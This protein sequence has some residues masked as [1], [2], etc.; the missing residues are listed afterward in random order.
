MNSAPATGHVAHVLVQ[1]PGQPPI[2]ANPPLANLP[3]APV[4]GNVLAAED[5]RGTKRGLEEENI[6][7]QEPSTEPTMKRART[8]SNP[9]EVDPIKNTLFDAISDHKTSKLKSVL[10]QHPEMLETPSYK[11]GGLTPLCLAAYLNSIEIIKLLIQS[12]AKVNACARNGSTPLMFAAHNGCI[13]AIELLIKKKADLN[14]VN[15]L[16]YANNPNTAPF[17]ALDFAIHEKHIE[18]CKKLIDLG[19]NFKQLIKFGDQNNQKSRTP[20]LLALE[21]DFTELF[22]WLIRFKAMPLNFIEPSTQLNLINA[23]ASQGSLKMICF[24]MEKRASLDASWVDK[25]GQERSGGIWSVA[26][27]WAK[28]NLTEALLARGF[29]PPSYASDM[30]SFVEQIGCN[31]STDLILHE[32]LLAGRSNVEQDGLTDLSLRRQPEKIIELINQKGHFLKNTLDSGRIAEYLCTGLSASFLQLVQEKFTNDMQSVFGRLC[33]RRFDTLS[34]NHRI[35]S[36]YAQQLQILIEY[37][38]EICGD[39]RLPMLFADKELTPQGEREMARMLKLQ[40]DLI[41]QGIAHL[42]I[43]F[44]HQVASLPDLCMNTYI[45]RTHHLN[46]VDLY[47]VLTEDWGLYDPIARSALRLVTEAYDRYRKA[48]SECIPAQL[49]VLSPAEQLKLMIVNVLEEWDKVP[50]IIAAF[51]EGQSAEEMDITT[52]LLFQQWRMFNEALGV[53]KE[54]PLSIGPRSRNEIRADRMTIADLS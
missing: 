48:T 23:A 28:H 31:L 24:F 16:R 15:I 20:L 54:R 41:L 34:S 35:I 50:E 7:S 51:R 29:R 39:P 1:L 22:N 46:E 49:G 12:G 36:T 32:Q 33:G 8:A 2:P 52:D 6:Y 53:T 14:A 18:A 27:A 17:T 25:N 3:V 21:S 42:R 44:D 19:A 40:C 38:S 9:T 37:L 43:R 47:R 13:E 26:S 4:L 30:K 10:R 45:S 5:P 11:S